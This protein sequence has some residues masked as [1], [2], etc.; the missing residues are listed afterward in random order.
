[1]Q[2]RL[3]A[4]R[5]LLEEPAQISFSFR[6]ALAQARERSLN[7]RRI[8][9]SRGF[10]ADPARRGCHRDSY[11]R[12]AAREQTTS[13]GARLR[14]LGQL[15]P[16]LREDAAFTARETLNSFASDLLQ[17]RIHFFGDKLLGIHM[18]VAI[19]FR[20][21]LMQRALDD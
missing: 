4:E 14:F 20:L 2:Q 17:Q 16:R 10:L 3:F 8:N 6:P 21:P 9:R 19:G 18:P 12:S 1:M 11:T 15:L 13:A 5:E 7:L